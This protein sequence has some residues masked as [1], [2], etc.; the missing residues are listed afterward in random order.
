[1]DKNGVQQEQTIEE[2]NNIIP[3]LDLMLTSWWYNLIY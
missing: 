3:W 1:M 2:F